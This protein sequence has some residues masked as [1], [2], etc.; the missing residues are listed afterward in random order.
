VRVR[1]GRVLAVQTALFHHPS[2]S[3]IAPCTQCVGCFSVRLLCTATAVPR[4]GNVSTQRAARIQRIWKGAYR[5]SLLLPSV[6]LPLCVPWLPL[7]VAVLPCLPCAVVWEPEEGRPFAAAVRCCWGCARGDTEGTK[8]EATQQWGGALTEMRRA[9]L[10][11]A[12]PDTTVSV[13]PPPPTH[14]TDACA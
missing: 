5:T 10:A 1:E 3:L 9:C 13:S 6:P 8:R 14:F 11:P 2:R 12:F 7:L 4:T